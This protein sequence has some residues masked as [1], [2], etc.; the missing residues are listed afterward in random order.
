MT[1]YRSL[2]RATLATSLDSTLGE[3]E[4]AKSGNLDWRRAGLEVRIVVDSKAVDPFRG[5]AFTLEFERSDNG[6]FGEKLAG[7]ARLEQLLDAVQRSEALSL[8][9]VIAARLAQPD[10]RHL[11]LV[12]E[13]VRPEYLKAFRPAKELEPRFWMRFSTVRDV[14]DWSAFL[15]RVLGVVVDRAGTLDPHALVLG[16]PLVW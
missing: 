16:K 9:N 5:G 6:K 4:F 12:P 15:E 11:A 8:R 2:L 1:N 14:A 10:Q 13:S 7:R 3:L